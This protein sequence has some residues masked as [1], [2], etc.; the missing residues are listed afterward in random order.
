MA[1][2]QKRS[3]RT[4]YVPDTTPVLATRPAAP[5]RG[6]AVE[7]I[8][9][10]IGETVY[11]WDLE[12]DALTWAGNAAAVLDVDRMDPL[13]TG[14]SYG[15]L[16]D[17]DSV[18]NRHE[19]VVNGTGVD[20][21]A[22]VPYEIAYALRLSRSGELRAVWVNDC[23]LWFADEGGRPVVA[24]G[25]VRLTRSQAVRPARPAAELPRRA[26]FLKLIENALAVARHYLTRYAF[27]VVSLDNLSD[28]S[29]AFGPMALDD[30]E[31]VIVE[32]LYGA[33]RNGDLAGRLSDSEIG[34]ILRVGDANEAAQAVKRILQ[35]TAAE[36]IPIDGKEIGPAISAGVV[37]IPGGAASLEDCLARG[38]QA[39]ADARSRGPGRYAFHA[40][41][42][43]SAWPP[44]PED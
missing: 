42:R 26:D 12:T 41:S 5:A 33:L 38:R 13:A 2:Q 28:I 7:T 39:Q 21:G 43:F 6:A 40:A 18:T 32:R 36:T 17:P 37:M 31:A 3:K 27:V 10:A 23:G 29:D 34:L 8:L 11:E 15:A 35:E 44:D 4:T 30:A 20:H 22:G 1:V 16:V 24:R 25:A 9:T 19:A 14:K